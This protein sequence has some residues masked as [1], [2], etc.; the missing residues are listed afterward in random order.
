MELDATTFVL[1]IINFLALL[2]LL[3]RLLYRPVRAALDT[4]AQAQASRQQALEDRQLAIDAEVARLA[5]VKAEWDAQRAAA[6]RELVGEVAA[7]RQ[8]RLAELTQ[9]LDAER[10]KTRARIAQQQQFAAAQQERELRERAA[11]FVADYLK[12][13]ASPALEAAV[14]E[15]FLGDL[16][17]QTGMARSALRDGWSD[18][19]ESPPDV[20]VSTA[21]PL[22]EATRG[23][24]EAQIQALMSAST[25]L[26]WR[27]DPQLVAG[28]CIHLPGHELE[29]S[30]RRGVE[31][32][33]APAE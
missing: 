2:W 21:Y 11:R 30:L 4:R 14:V 8:K 31:A 16:D 7:L 33:A 24:I 20:E 12:R 25:R 28:I 9:E 29:A 13:L 5:Q 23:R 19:G 22:P 32:F 3:N 18:R 1:E 10:E 27:V 17:R 6:E 15:L 26:Q